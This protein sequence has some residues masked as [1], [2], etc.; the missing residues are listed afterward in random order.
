MSLLEQRSK[1]QRIAELAP[2]LLS[3]EALQAMKSQLLQA[4]GTPWG[5]EDTSLPPLV[6]QYVRQ[7]CAA[8]A[9]LPVLRELSTLALICDHLLMGRPAEGLDVAFQRLKSLEMVLAGHTW[10]TSQKVELLARADQGVAG[11][12]E[13]QVA[14]KEALLDSKAKG[15]A[16]G[17]EKGPKGKGG[18]KGKEKD[19]GKG[20][21]KGG[22]KDDGKKTG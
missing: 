3:S 21:T 17:S 10:L 11:R 6:M 7:H 1:I 12:G 9:S 20:K 13:V 19:K 2:G 22:S 14:Q 15:A 4:S 16:G 18:S 5:V 8:K